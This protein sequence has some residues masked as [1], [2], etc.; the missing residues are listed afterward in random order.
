MTVYKTR[1][2]FLGYAKLVSGLWRFI[3]LDEPGSPAAVGP[4]YRSRSELLADLTDY[5]RRAWK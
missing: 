5:V 3:A 4:F 2:R 1:F